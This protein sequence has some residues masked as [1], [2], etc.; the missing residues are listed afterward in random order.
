MANVQ[1]IELNSG[2]D[3]TLSLVARG[4]ANA[5]YELTGATIAW[6]AADRESSTAFV[7]KTGT[8]AGDGAGG[9]TVAITDGDFA[10]R[11][12]VY[13]WHATAT[14]SGATTVIGR[15]PLIVRGGVA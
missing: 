13:R 8:S 10:N 5:F 11:E 4:D 14:I 9:Y 6:Y 3:R 15:G 12:G 2:A 1:T 7:T